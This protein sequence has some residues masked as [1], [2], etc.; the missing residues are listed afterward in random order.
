MIEKYLKNKETEITDDDLD[1]TSLENDLR[2]G[3][4]SEK[5]VQGRIDTAVKTAN[6]DAT[7]KYSQ[8]E[9]TYNE[10]VKTLS[11]VNE[12]NA[13]LSL[14]MKMMKHGF[15]EE[16]FDEISKLR[17]SLYA[18]EKD[19]EKAIAGI[20]EKFKGTY[21][22]EGD[23]KPETPPDGEFGSNGNS[24]RKDVKITRNTPLSELII[25]KGE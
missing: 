8:L 3:Y 16:N 5:D 2:K 11:A 23:S 10:T 21:F 9:N 24:H 14:Q 15:K 20:A 12:K 6:T 17:K 1:I 4:V 13:T 22:K 19:D 7:T 25:K 18:D